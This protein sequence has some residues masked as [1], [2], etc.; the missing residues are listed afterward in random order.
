MAFLKWPDKD[1]QEVLDYQINWA[2]RLA[3]DDTIAT[4][5][6]TISGTGLV[7]QS[8]SF[9]DTFTTIWLTGGTLGLKYILT[10][11]VTTTDGRTMDQSVTIK[12]KER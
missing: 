3:V 5:T 8:D 10:N 12:I 1:P 11:R 9:E 4:S 7:K 6:W 2:S